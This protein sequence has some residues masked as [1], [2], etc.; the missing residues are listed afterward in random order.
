[1]SDRRG[2]G[3]GSIAT[4]AGSRTGLRD[5]SA[6]APLRAA[7]E[8]RVDDLA[9]RILALA[10]GVVQARLPHAVG[11]AVLAW[12]GD[13][14]GPIVMTGSD[15]ARSAHDILMSGE[16]GSAGVSGP[17]ADHVRHTL[18]SCRSEGRQVTAPVPASAWRQLVTEPG[19]GE[20]WVIGEPLPAVNGVLVAW[21][22]RRPAPKDLLGLDQAR[23][24]VSMAVSASMELQ[25]LVVVPPT[26]LIIEQA[27]GVLMAR[28][29]VGSEEAFVLLRRLSQ[30]LNV[31]VRELARTLVT[32]PRPAGRRPTVAAA[33][34]SGGTSRV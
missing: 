8:E 3:G 19:A 22:T 29:G 34:R 32:T 25:G 20:G 31:P 24:V 14:A 7:A 4:G 26:R 27:K 5:R 2:L 13:D 1:V 15:L 21:L 11:S 16:A 33:A 12:R 9:E 10:L 18:A 17:E 23:E 6:A 28:N 30:R